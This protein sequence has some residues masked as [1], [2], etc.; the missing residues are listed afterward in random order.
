LICA[1]AGGWPYVHH[2]GG[3][4]GFVRVR[5]ETTLGFADFR[6]NRRY[7]GVGNLA[8]DERVSP[9]FMDHANR[10]RQKLP[11][12]ARIVPLEDAATLERLQLPDHRARGW[13]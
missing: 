5:D 10:R 7:V 4:A 6:G 8:T 13:R 9:F 3:P 2:R 11:G 1:G 12:R